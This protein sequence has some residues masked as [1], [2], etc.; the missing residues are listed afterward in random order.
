MLFS[1]KVWDTLSV[2]DQKVI[3]QAAKESFRT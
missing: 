1:K 2:E 3:R